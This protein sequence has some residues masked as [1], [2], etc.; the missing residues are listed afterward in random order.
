[1]DEMEDALHPTLVKD[2]FATLA[3]VSTGENLREWTYYVKSEEE[4]FLR[5]N[6][7]L[8]DKTVFPIDIH[9]AVDRKWSMYEK[10][11]A[12]LKK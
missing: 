4:F 11:K 2:G 5:L 9:T 6:E 10:F 3:L 8:A 12:G 7:A 1:M